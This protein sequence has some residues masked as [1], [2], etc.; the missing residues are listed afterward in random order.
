MGLETVKQTVHIKKRLMWERNFAAEPEELN[1]LGLH[2]ITIKLLFYLHILLPFV[3][4]SK[5]PTMD[6]SMEY[7]TNLEGT[8]VM[9]DAIAEP[10]FIFAAQKW[11][12]LE[13][14]GEELN[15]L[16]KEDT[17]GKFLCRPASEE[18]DNRR[19][20]LH[21]YK[22]VPIAGTETKKA[23]IQA[24]QAVDTPPDHPELITFWTFIKLDCDIVP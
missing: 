23:A 3:P 8:Q 14:L 19:A 22:Q 16:T 21:I 17:A 7:L 4:I 5:L 6:S 15:R 12:I 24:S 20:F 1:F 11:I 18:D 9:F 2:E 10:P 13:K